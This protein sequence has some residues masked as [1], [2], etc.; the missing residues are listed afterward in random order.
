MMTVKKETLVCKIGLMGPFGGGNLGDAA[1]QQAMIENIHKRL[2]AAQIFGF[3]MI[4][5]D[6][7]ARHGIPSFSIGRVPDR[8]WRTNAKELSF[9]ERLAY[10]L[11][12]SSSPTLQRINR[13][14][15]RVPLECGLIKKAFQNLDDFNLLIISG[16]GQLDDYFGGPWSHPYTIL[17]FVIAAKARGAKVFIV[18][19][20]AG[21]ID[22]SLSKFF[23]RRSLAIADYRS[24]RD[25]ASRQ[26]IK[27][28]GFFR[29]D[30][31]YPDLA[32][33]LPVDPYLVH[34][35]RGLPSS[36]FSG[37]VVGI[38]PMAY[39]DP[40]VWPRKDSKVYVGYLNKLA[41]FTGW[42]V[43]R[44]YRIVLFPGEAAH[45]K[46]VIADFLE[47]GCTYGLQMGDTVC[48][49]LIETVDELMYTLAGVD[50][51]VAS[52]YHGVL[53]PM[54]LDK[55]VLA[56]SYHP[57]IDELMKDTSQA[58]YCLPID[59]FTLAE[60]QECFTRLE[61]N[62]DIVRAQIY[63]CIEEYRQALE[64]QYDRIFKDL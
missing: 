23:I 18:S 55:P 39:Y 30:L 36:K 20:G 40:R 10:R 63:N 29:N 13:W 22:A 11:K 12:S 31:V 61:A 43:K 26:L 64:E 45:D 41:E 58:D 60:L 25:D 7:E 59:H 54:L 53:L 50:L 33:S 5:Q 56:M 49:P 38:G 62:Q 16:G 4:P 8:S 14:V 6:T 1:I 44:G 34:S 46:D 48:A 28:I 52:R 42:L 2:P 17:K 24:F 27:R 35:P 19:V 21:P 51:V 3:S 47:L 57:K 37:Q 9:S 32:H 15:A